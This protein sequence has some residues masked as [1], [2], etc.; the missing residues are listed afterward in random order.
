MLKNILIIGFLF[1]ALLLLT[2]ATGFDHREDD[3]YKVEDWEV[4]VCSKWGGTG[5]AQTYTGGVMSTEFHKQ[6]ATVQAHLKEHYAG[7]KNLY[8]YEVSWYL[9]PISGQEKYEVI[10]KG[11]STEKKIATGSAP[12]TAGDAGYYAEQNTS[13]NYTSVIL[14]YESGSIEAPIVE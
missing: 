4:E 6:A 13:V 7:D 14:D 10:L 5:Q 2:A 9:Q 8:V 3:W 11:D 1:A 12:S